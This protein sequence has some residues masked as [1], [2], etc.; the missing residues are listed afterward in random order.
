[1]TPDLILPALL[2]LAG[3]VWAGRGGTDVVGSWVRIHDELRDVHTPRPS[4][5]AAPRR[6]PAPW[7]VQPRAIDWVDAEF[8]DDDRLALSA[9]EL[10]EI[11][12]DVTPVTVDPAPTR[13][14]L[15]R[16]RPAIGPGPR[17]AI[18]GPR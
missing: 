15:T 8:V 13:P 6:V 5:S 11:W 3:I 4:V 1:M 2:L 14:A 18:E 12:L 16:P 7:P 9:S 17:R 10:A